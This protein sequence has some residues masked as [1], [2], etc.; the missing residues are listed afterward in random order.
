MAEPIVAV[1]MSGGVDSS[2]AAAFLKKKGF[3]V[4]ICVEV[5]GKK[6][7]FGS[8]EEIAR[9]VE[10]TGC[11]FCIDVAHVLALYG[12]YEFE[13]IER[14]FKEKKWHVHFSG[15]DFGE[16]GEKKHLPV[17]REEWVKVLN[18]LKGLDKDVVLICEAPDPV[19][20]AVQGL[21]VWEEI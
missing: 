6:N 10:E 13:K 14:A 2:V 18:W 7:V 12:R 5:M 21:K 11:G 9:L 20:D 19:G 4:E 1:A 16:K 8:I 3:D 15:M 17:E